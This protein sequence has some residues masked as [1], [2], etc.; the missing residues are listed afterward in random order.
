MSRTVSFSRNL[1]FLPCARR[2]KYIESSP[3]SSFFR[4]V[5]IRPFGV[6]PHAYDFETATYL[7]GAFLLILWREFLEVSEL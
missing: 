6:G 3:H 5:D 4:V 1:F 2:R 7:I